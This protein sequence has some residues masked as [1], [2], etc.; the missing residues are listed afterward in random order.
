MS[1]ELIDQLIFFS[2]KFNRHQI[3]YSVVEKEALAES[4][5]APVVVY[6]DHNP[7]TFLHSLRID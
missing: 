3:N 5:M 2:K 7:L 1:R 6:T 4:G